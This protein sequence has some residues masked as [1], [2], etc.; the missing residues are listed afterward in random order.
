MCSDAVR[1]FERECYLIELN[2]GKCVPQ[3]TAGAMLPA[4]GNS[5]TDQLTELTRAII[6]SRHELA[7]NITHF[8]VM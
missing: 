3:R 2:I 4:R 6:S 5:L 8:P 1:S 7:H